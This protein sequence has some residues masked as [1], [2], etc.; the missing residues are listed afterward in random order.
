M[1]LPSVISGMTTKIYLLL[2]FV[3][4]VQRFYLLHNY[5]LLMPTD[6]I[7]TVKIFS[8]GALIIYFLLQETLLGSEIQE[9]LDEVICLY[10]SLICKNLDEDTGRNIG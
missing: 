9:I 5:I 1:H 7:F 3:P 6:V 4:Y 10:H 8:C 2:N